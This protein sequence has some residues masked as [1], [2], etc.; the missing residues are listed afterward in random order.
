MIEADL[1]EVYGIDVEA[2]ILRARSWRWLRTRIIGLLS[3]ESR[4]A[5]ALAPPDKRERP[6]KIPR[7]R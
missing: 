6:Q 5:R 1:H 3:C 4:L 7:R 2:G